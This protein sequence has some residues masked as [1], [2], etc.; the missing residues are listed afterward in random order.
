MHRQVLFCW[1]V[2]FAFG[3]T[4]CL[5]DPAACRERCGEGRDGGTLAAAEREQ[6]FRPPFAPLDASCLCPVVPGCVPGAA[7]GGDPSA[8]S[9]PGG[10]AG[11]LSSGVAAGG[12]GG[13]AVDDVD[14]TDDA[15]SPVDGAVFSGDKGAPGPAAPS[16]PGDLVVT[17]IM[18]DPAAAT[19][20]SGEWVELFNPGSTGAFDLHGCELGDDD[21][22]EG[23]IEGGLQIT[24]GGFVAVARSADPGFAPDYICPGLSL[25]NSGGDQVV[26]R[27]NGV[28]IDRAVYTTTQPGHSLS[29]DPALAGAGDNDDPSCWCVVE[30]VYGA[31]D[32][33]TPATANPACSS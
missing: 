6:S 4:G 24:P 27:C 13:A 9:P 25:R 17:E 29:L 16:R 8:L 22:M 21:G 33:G 26:L 15:S 12:G 20:A 32:R 5:E 30:S 1:Q 3:L 14:P 11:T 19:D 2:V 28:V 31:G 23:A 18:A 10:G 7:P